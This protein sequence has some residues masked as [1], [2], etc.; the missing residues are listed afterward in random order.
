MDTA[1]QQLQAY[2]TRAK[3]LLRPLLL[4]VA[5][6]WVI[7]LIDRVF[8]H[9]ALDSLGIAPRRAI[10]LT[11]IFFAPLLHDSF[12]HLLANTGPLLVLGF[13]VL[14]RQGRRI[15]AVSAIILLIS[16]L[17]TWLT[18]PPNTVHIGASGLV[19]GY[20]AFLVVSAYYERSLTAVVLAV[21]VIA[22][23]WGLLGGILPAAGIS[24][25][26]HLFGLVGGAV[27][28]YLFSRRPVGAAAS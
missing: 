11:G 25:Q 7:E 6:L 3:Q 19:F 15:V 22:L 8:F 12:A 14:A 20:F 4:A 16:G 24:W 17:G 23:Y 21:L 28:A 10:G 27:A 2:G 9:G 13:L 26:G 5:L 18:G 1:Q